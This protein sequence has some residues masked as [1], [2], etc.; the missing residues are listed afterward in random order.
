MKIG[1]QTESKPGNIYEIF[2]LVQS[3]GRSAINVVINVR[4]GIEKWLS[5]ERSFKDRARF[6]LYGQT[7]TKK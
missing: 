5:V 6:T 4:S 7:R 2:E 1:A 3:N